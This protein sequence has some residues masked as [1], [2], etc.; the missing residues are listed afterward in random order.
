MFQ[1]RNEMSRKVYLK[2]EVSMIAIIE[3]GVEVGDFVNEL[4]YSFSDKTGK[5]TILDTTIL[6]YAITD[7]K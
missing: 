7:S 1:R 2:V 5:A 3:E 6:D 4:D